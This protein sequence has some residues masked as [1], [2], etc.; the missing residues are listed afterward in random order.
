MISIIRQ[1]TGKPAGFKTVIGT[2]DWLDDLFKAINQRGIEIAPDFITI[3]SGDGGTGA[4]PMSLMDNVGLPIKQS[5]PLLINK[6]EQYGLRKRIKVIASGK[7]ITPVEVA[8]ALATGADFITSARGFMFSLGCIQALQCNKN[9]CPTGITTHNKNLQSG[10]DPHNK[11]ERV[12]NYVK[13]M[14]Y[15]VGVIAH[16]CGVS[17]PRQFRRHHAYMVSPQG[18]CIPLNELYSNES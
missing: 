17:E 15:E 3:D 5:L 18:K 12:R 10:L 16:S 8:W 11:A 1:S 4:A 2:R 6:I 9:T 14:V 7:L 13:N